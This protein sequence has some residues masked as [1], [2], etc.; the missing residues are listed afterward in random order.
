M[1]LRKVICIGDA[2]ADD[3]G[4]VGP[5]LWALSEAGG[6]IEWRTAEASDLGELAPGA[7]DLVVV[8]LDAP[9]LGGLAARMRIGQIASRMPVL[10]VGTEDS[11]A[12]KMWAVGA[13]VVGYATKPFDRAALARF[14]AKM[15]GTL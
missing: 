7:A 14:L 9:S 6:L 3:P 11:R 2:H 4:I 8:D 12:R 13:G 1:A 10:V 5:L 15:F